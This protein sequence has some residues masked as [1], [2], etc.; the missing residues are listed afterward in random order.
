MLVFAAGEAMLTAQAATLLA[1][2]AG[3]LLAGAAV[4]SF[5]APYVP[6]SSRSAVGMHFGSNTSSLT[7]CE[8]FYRAWLCAG[9]W[10]VRCCLPAC[11]GQ[12]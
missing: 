4:A 2:D 3:S 5:M 7:M 8:T 12:R 10:S 9:V 6:P 11:N 1:W